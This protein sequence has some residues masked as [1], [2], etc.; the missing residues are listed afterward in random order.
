MFYDDFEFE[1]EQ[2]AIDFINNK[3]KRCRKCGNEL[4]YKEKFY[5]TDKLCNECKGMRS[6]DEIDDNPLVIQNKKN[7]VC[8]TRNAD[9]SFI[10]EDDV[11][12]KCIVSEKEFFKKYSQWKLNNEKAEKAWREKQALTLS[13]KKQNNKITTTPKIT[14]ERLAEIISNYDLGQGININHDELISIVWEVMY[15]RGINKTF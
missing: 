11:Q 5:N 9:G 7:H 13:T 6:F 14:D 1:R 4:H 12:K 2:E 15:Y 10:L 3:I 8:S